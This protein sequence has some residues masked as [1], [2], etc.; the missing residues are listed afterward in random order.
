MARLPKKLGFTQKPRHHVFINPRS[1]AAFTR[2][3]KCDYPTRLR[4]FPLVVH[5]APVNRPA[6][7]NKTCR[8]CIAC[9]LIIIR[10][11]DFDPLV[12]SLIGRAIDL[13]EEEPYLPLGTMDRE[14]WKQVSIGLLTTGDLPD[15]IIPFKNRW[16]FEPV[17]RWVKVD[18]TKNGN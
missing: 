10:R 1:D 13:L 18:G 7:I 9:D 3:P 12:G 16:N 17:P 14:G 2:C 4:K 11:L 5:L 8:Y 15:I 6:V